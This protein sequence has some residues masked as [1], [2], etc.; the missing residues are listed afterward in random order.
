MTATTGA[1]RPPHSAFDPCALASQIF[2]LR[3]ARGWSTRVLAAHAGI[4]QPYVVA[5]ERAAREPLGERAPVPTVDVLARLAGA[6][7]VEPTALLAVA[8]RPVHHVLVVADNATS[9]VALIRRAAADPQIEWL[10][11]ADSTRVGW[12]EPSIHPRR[13]Q[14]RYDSAAV[15]GQ[16]TTELS[17]HHTASQAALGL[18]FADTSRVMTTLAGVA[19]ILELEHRWAGLVD[20][21]A[22]AAGCRVRWIAC[23]YQLDA[24]GA[25]SDPL[26]AVTDLLRSHDDVWF[27]RRRRLSTG[28]PAARAVLE[29]VRPPGKDP[30]PW[31]TATTRAL[32]ELDAA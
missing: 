2:Q 5:L 18:V 16:L 27:L 23:V 14:Q 3:Q 13:G 29:G 12:P 11:A 10:V 25:L 8:L 22:V 17:H 4:S 31:A 9:P 20:R 32:A 1:L 7:G 6:L 26:A 19:T 30:G 24:L 15:T 28:W 21:A